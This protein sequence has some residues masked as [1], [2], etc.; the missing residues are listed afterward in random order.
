MSRQLD[1]A[2]E[3][4]DQRRPVDVDL[5]CLCARQSWSFTHAKYWTP[6]GELKRIYALR[7]AMNLLDQPDVD[8]RRV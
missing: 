1:H 7:A 6:D 4:R 3:G 2:K 8:P 5:K